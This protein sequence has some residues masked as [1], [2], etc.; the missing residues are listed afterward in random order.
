MK[1]VLGRNI[2]HIKFSHAGTPRPLNDIVKEISDY[3]DQN[4][5]EYSPFIKNPGKL[6]GRQVNHRFELQNQSFQWFTGTVLDY[7][8]I[9][10]MHTVLYEGED[11]NLIQDLLTGDY[12]NTVTCSY[13]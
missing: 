3:I 13:T 4:P 10:K 9:T 6:V 1:K 11:D 8:A 12:F 2:P 7:D 5:C